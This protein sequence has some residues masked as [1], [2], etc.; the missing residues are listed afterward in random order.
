MEKVFIVT[1]GEKHEGGFVDSVWMKRE[2]AEG[3]KAVI[4]MGMLSYE[5]VEVEEQMVK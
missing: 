5:W 1:R 3:R 4:E 2:D